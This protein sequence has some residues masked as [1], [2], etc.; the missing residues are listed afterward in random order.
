MREVDGSRAAGM[1]TKGAAL[2]KNRRYVM[3]ELHAVRLWTRVERA[4]FASAAPDEAYERP[5]ER[6]VPAANEVH[7]YLPV[8]GGAARF[9]RRN[10]HPCQGRIAGRKCARTSASAC[11]AE[12][13]TVSN[14]SVP[15]T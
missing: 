5:S 6:R 9:A 2:R 14:A 15:P 1:V 4:S 13:S 3:A 8:S 10:L 11:R 12:C 7:G